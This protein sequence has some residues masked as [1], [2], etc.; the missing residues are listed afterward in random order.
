MVGV[1]FYIKLFTHAH[2]LMLVTWK[3]RVQTL[4]AHKSYKIVLSYTH[5]IV[6]YCTLEIKNLLWNF[7]LKWFL[8][9][10]CFKWKFQPDRFLNFS[11]LYVQFYCIKPQ[12]WILCLWFYNVHL[13]PDSLS[14]TLNV[15]LTNLGH[16]FQH[17]LCFWMFWGKSSGI[18]RIENSS[19]MAM[20]LM[21][22]MFHLFQLRVREHPILGPFVQDLSTWVEHRLL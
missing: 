2:I 5:V 8:C 20:A 14:Q 11:F 15:W 6:L 1:A 4:K 9:E 19:N 13:V 17:L 7:S 16:Q 12:M 21:F 3:S 18:S 22:L 10:G